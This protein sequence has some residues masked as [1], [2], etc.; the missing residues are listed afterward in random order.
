MHLIM[1]T[2]QR[3]LEKRGFCCE[4]KKQISRYFIIE[5]HFLFIGTSY[6]YKSTTLKS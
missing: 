3:Q 6:G 1:Q 5:S 2:K 4:Q